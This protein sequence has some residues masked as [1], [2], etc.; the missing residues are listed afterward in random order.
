MIFLT[1][2]RTKKALIDQ[3]SGFAKWLEKGLKLSIKLY[4]ISYTE[5]YARAFKGNQNG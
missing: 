4:V 5:Q 1:F 3:K 2:L